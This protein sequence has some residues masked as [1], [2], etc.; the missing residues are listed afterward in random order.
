MACSGRRHRHPTS[1]RSNR[2]WVT[3]SRRSC[4]RLT[5]T[6][7]PPPERVVTPAPQLPPPSPPRPPQSTTQPP[8]LNVSTAGSGENTVFW[9][10]GSGF[11]PGTVTV[12]GARIGDGQVFDFYWLASASGTGALSFDIPL[13]CVSGLVIHFSA[14]DGWMPR[15][16]HIGFGV[17]RLPPPARSRRKRELLDT[18]GRFANPAAAQAAID[19]WL[20]DYNRLRP[21]QALDMDVCPPGIRATPGRT[22]R[23]ARLADRSRCTRGTGPPRHPCRTA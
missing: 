10:T 1:V 2:S 19:G 22:S 23:A 21:H 13:P 11:L 15:T 9:L 17:T 12:R 5:C 7:T 6:I 8:I 14:N 4:R 18:R 3:G 16:S 20:A